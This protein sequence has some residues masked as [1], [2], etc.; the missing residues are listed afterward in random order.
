MRRLLSSTISLAT[1]AVAALWWFVPDSYPYGAAD[2][3]TVGVNHWIE[4]DLGVSLMV[5]SGVLGVLLALGVRSWP[6]CVGVGAVVESAFF[7]LIMSDASVLSSIGY[8]LIPVVLLGVVALVAVGCVRRHP[9][10]YAMAL[11]LLAG[12]ALALTTAD[13]V[14]R[15]LANVASGLGAYGGRIAWSW[16]MAIAAVTWA[17][18]AYGSFASDREV[19]NPRWGKTVTILAAF[20]GVPYALTRLSW[21]TP[22]PLGGFD[23]R[24]GHVELFA[25]V[26][27]DTAIRIQ[28]FLIGMSAVLAAVLTLGLIGRWGEVV[29]RWVP[30]VGGR[31]V[32]VMMAVG[33]GAFATVTLC[34]SAPGVLARA[35]QMSSWV[36]GALFVLLFPCPVWGPLLGAAVFAYWRRR[37]AAQTRSSRHQPGRVRRIPPGTA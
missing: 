1:L 11:L 36:D 33:P 30:W 24:T 3:V 25:A 21:V 27:G 7:L 22:W 37:N 35:V 23:P 18:L 20:G 4:R 28:G 16:A 5:A 6:R 8:A 32:P 17:W 2:K 34:V 31:A 13:V 29:P 9:V 12:L 14:Y 19:T 10:A 26:S 15:Y